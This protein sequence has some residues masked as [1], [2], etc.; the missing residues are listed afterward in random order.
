MS[1]GTSHRAD[2]L[3]GLGLVLIATGLV[4]LTVN[5]GSGV[6]IVFPFGIVG[7]NVPVAMVVAL[8]GIMLLMVILSVWLAWRSF[9]TVSMFN[10]PIPS[11]ERV[12]P[13]CGRA[14]PED[15]LFCPYC[16]HS[17]T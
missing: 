14:L 8:A 10:P 4:I 1:V 7:E 12:C 2:L 6:I 3:C 9:E 13:V 17:L 15:A 16:G 5:S 11:T